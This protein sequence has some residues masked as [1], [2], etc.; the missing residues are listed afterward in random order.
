M[1]PQ[2]RSNREY[3]RAT[4][5]KRIRIAKS[6]STKRLDQKSCV[7]TSLRNHRKEISI[8]VARSTNLS[9]ERPARLA[10]RGALLRLTSLRRVSLATVLCSRDRQ[11]LSA[12]HL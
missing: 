7:I 1:S 11:F 9:T 6:F 3:S 8:P 4:P 5:V 10:E 12:R 2:L